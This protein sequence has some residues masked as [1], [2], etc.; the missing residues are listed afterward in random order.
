MIIMKKLY[1]KSAIAL[2]ALGAGLAGMPAH[3]TQVSFSG[4]SVAG[5]A[6]T[7]GGVVGGLGDTWQTHN[8]PA[9]LFSN[10]GMSNYLEAPGV[11][12]ALNFSNGNGNWATSFQL[13][14]NNSQSGIGF[15]GIAEGAVPSG[16]SNNFTVKSN[17]SD[18]STW[19]TWIASYNLF[20]SVSGL[21]QQV[22][23][24]APTGTRLS[25]GETYS[26]DVNFAGIMTNQSGWAASFDDRVNRT[27]LPEPGSM[28]LVGLG[29]VAMLAASRRKQRK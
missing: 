4:G 21:N 22:L 26:M 12:N 28:A 7:T 5:N 24:T 19:V 10:F 1:L 15:R 6:A 20:D 17:V 11:F 16:Q 29:L 9:L 14:M 25:Q 3:A 8:G 23:F 2:A 18:P 27:N 13:T